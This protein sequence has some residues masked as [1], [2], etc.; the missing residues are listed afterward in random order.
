MLTATLVS[1]SF[2]FPSYALLAHSTKIWLTGQSRI[3][4]AITLP[5][6]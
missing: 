2:F 5:D 3:K 4:V 6:L 1:F